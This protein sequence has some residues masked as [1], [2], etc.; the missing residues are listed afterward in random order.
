MHTLGSL[1]VYSAHQ[2][3]KQTLLDDL[4]SIHSRR[5]APDKTRVDMRILRHML[6]LPELSIRQGIGE[7]LSVA[8]VPVL[9]STDVGATLPPS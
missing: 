8:L 6:Q 2:L 7:G 3:K 5:D 1:L 4:V 9:F